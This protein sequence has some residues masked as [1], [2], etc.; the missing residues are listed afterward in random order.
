MYILSAFDFQS[1]PQ[2]SW[3]EKY[4]VKGKS[5][6]LTQIRNYG[7]Q[8]LEVDRC[9]FLYMYKGVHEGAIASAAP[10][11]IGIRIKYIILV[12]LYLS[13]VLNA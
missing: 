7:R 6:S 10:P 1:C 5:L 11:E 4:Q 3:E 2:S 9:Y 8:I 13:I 12:S